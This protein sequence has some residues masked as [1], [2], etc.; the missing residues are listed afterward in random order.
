MILIASPCGQFM[1]RSFVE[2]LYD[3]INDLRGQGYVI[4]QR[5][6]Q[7]PQ[8][9]ANRN[10][11]MLDALKLRA[12][13]ILLID[14]DMEFCEGDVRKLESVGADVVTGVC[15]RADGGYALYDY[16]DADNSISPLSAPKSTVDICGTAFLYIRANVVNLLLAAVKCSWNRT[17][18]IDKYLG[19]PFNIV[20]GANGIQFGEDVSFCL[21]LRELGISVNVAV[22]AKIS[23]EKMQIIK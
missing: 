11:A 20:T 1:S 14:T 10:L 7:G 21:R 19:Y 23:H 22:G 9:H 8:V 6:Y 12:D 17:N 15:K 3:T 16:C 18:V 13:A 5:F 2:C 4:E